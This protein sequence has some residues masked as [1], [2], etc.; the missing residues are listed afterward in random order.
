MKYA[1]PC[2]LEPERDPAPKFEGFLNVSFPDV[3]GALTCGKGREK[4]LKMAEDALT[5]MLGVY[6]ERNQELPKPSKLKKGQ[7]LVAVPPLSAAKLALY[8]AMRRRG[9][10]KAELARRLGISESAVKQMLMPDRYSHMKQ[11]ARALD[12]LGCRLVVEELA[13]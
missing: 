12:I 7:E 11:V 10:G 9:I 4:A 6:V 8:S 5:I 3:P 1:Y 2:N 13:A